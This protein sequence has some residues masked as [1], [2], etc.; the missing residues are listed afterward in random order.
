MRI[1][2]AALARFRYA[3]GRADA[4]ADFDAELASH[5]ELHIDD[6][7][8]AGLTP[9]E[10]RRHALVKLGGVESTRQRRRERAGVPWLEHLAQDLRFAAR[11]LRKAQGFTATAVATLALGAGA[12]LAIFAFVN[13]ALLQP[14]PYRDPSRLMN[15]TES[16]AELP[17]AALSHANYL[18]WKRMNTVFGALEAYKSTGLAL[19]SPEG[20]QLLQVGL[21]TPGF[22]RTLGVVPALGRDFLESE[23]QPSAPRVAVLTHAAW[24]SRFGGS[25]DVVGRTISIEGDP[26][27]IVGVLPASFHFAP[28]GFAEF[29]IP[30]RPTTGCDLRRS[31]HSMTAVGRLKDGVTAEQA[32][33]E[34]TGIAA[35]L[36][37]QYPDANKGQS[38]SVRPLG[39]VI[40]GN[41]KPTL[42]ALAGGAAL[43]LVIALVNVVSL[44]LVRSEGRKRELAVRSTLGASGGRLARQFLTESIVLTAAGMTGG[45][46][47]AAAAIRLLSA[48]ISKDMLARMPFLAAARVDGTV[49]LAAAVLAAVSV[50]LFAV[51]P[52]VRLRLGDL[53]EGLTEGARGS[54]GTVWRRLGFRLVVVELA[55]AMV[56]LV[57]ASLLG[58]AVYRLLNVDLG[59]E[60]DGLATLQMAAT[61]TRFN[62]DAAAIRLARDVEARVQALPGIE[63][64]ALARTLPVSFNGNT[65]WIRVV[66]RPWTGRHIEVN[67]REVTPGYFTTMRS[68]ILSGRGFTRDDRE[69]RPLVAVI[70]KTMALK[71]F[72]GED[73]IGKQ[74]GD[75]DLAPDSIKT[76]VGVVDDIHE[77]ALDDEMWPAAYYPLDQDPS[78]GFW[79]IVR[80]AQEPSSVL[81]ALDAAVRAIGPEIGTRNP[82]ALRERITDSPVAYLRRSS[83]WLAGG[84]AALALLLSV[85]G[86]YGVIAYSVGQ[87]TREIGLR[88]AM[89]AGK[90]AVYRLILG[91]AG[92]LILF[93]VLLGAAGAVAAARLMKTLLFGTTPWDV[94]TLV[95]VAVVLASA[96]LA[97]SYLPARRAAS[98]SPMDA[99][100]VE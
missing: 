88:I 97:A 76:I 16:T 35:A 26:T 8:R 99:L 48:L 37:R 42:L 17:L 33:A 25:R 24:H 32:R 49:L 23:D 69:G 82:I 27:T 59:F 52:A 19:A 54:S 53:R 93:G 63:S 11:Q 95:V 50:L 31:C 34:M 85:I 6:N 84:F 80:T 55:T 71:H 28:L 21:A 5:L 74:F 1:L 65:D 18:D 60:P 98:V 61:G 4:E 20:A 22:F 83:T 79:V 2:R 77:G 39:D 73:P 58:Q 41:L 46:L 40:V 47:L 72:A 38:A 70:N 57:G 90:S 15:V 67:Q 62:E 94:P 44:L 43:L 68:R 81:R 56:L 36:E 78:S 10:A 14:L 91:E 3:L 75:R 86:L 64:V 89:G 12:A 7:L 13:A 45:V 51:A 30:F 96:A 100:R 66:G 9:E 87:R 29:W 92:R